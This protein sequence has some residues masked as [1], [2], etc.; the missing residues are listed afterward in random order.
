MKKTLNIKGRILDLS[1]P[2][3]MGILNIT[4]DSFFE[5]SRFFDNKKELLRQVKKMMEDGV[6]IIDVGGYSTRPNAADITV[7]EELRRVIP[8]IDEIKSKWP[9]SIISIDTFRAEVAQEAITNGA[10][11][12]ND[13][14]GGDLD[15]DLPQVVATAKV[16]YI[17]MHTR[18][19]PQTMNQLTDY[20]DI[21][22]DVLSELQQK[23]IRF[24]KKGIKDIIIDPGFGFAKTLDQNYQLLNKLTTLHAIE[25]PILVGVSRKSMIWKLLS[26]TP[27]DAL[28]ATTALNM[29]C[30]TKG[31]AI[32]R[33]H[34]V[35]EA[36]QTI[37][38]YRQLIG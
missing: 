35:K 11:I 24:E 16:P 6:D 25:R 8:I 7:R 27:E 10:D 23:V 5:G 33:V 3:V 17:I 12:I 15:P 2:K 36:K 32:L 4:P 14:S 18:G 19:T 31:A 21:A 37:D 26:I 29:Y 30:L 28:N 1:T 34:D 13:I 22:V 9:D 20:S 38:L